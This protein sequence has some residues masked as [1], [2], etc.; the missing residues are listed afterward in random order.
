MFDQFEYLNYTRYTRLGGCEIAQLFGRH[1]GE[2]PTAALQ[3]DPE[4]PD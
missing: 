2:L 3:P 1:T 4:I